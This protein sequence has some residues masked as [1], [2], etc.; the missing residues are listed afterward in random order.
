MGLGQMMLGRGAI[1]AGVGG[2]SAYAATGDRRS[3]LWG[4]G[5]GM[6][7]G[8]AMGGRA[9]RFLAKKGIASASGTG[10]WSTGRSFF[11]NLFRG[12]VRGATG[13][14]SNYMNAGVEQLAG[15]VG[16]R[17]GLGAPRYSSITGRT[18]GS[19]A[20]QHGERMVQGAGIELGQGSTPAQMMSK[21]R[22]ARVGPY[23][24][25]A[26]RHSRFSRGAGV[27][28]MGVAGMWG[29]SQAAGGLFAGAA[30][31]GGGVGGYHA[32]RHFMGKGKTGAVLGMALGNYMM[33]G[34]MSNIGAGGGQPSYQY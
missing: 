20:W 34:H 28:A 25:T 3:A 23:G 9:G 31:I 1:G 7:G 2:F 22:G 30:T 33:G 29:L 19:R 17:R 18:V 16:F 13:A 12:D 24:T 10:A 5:I 8:A 21:L 27:A 26:A 14:V 11:G 4:A 15:T 32:G 6:A